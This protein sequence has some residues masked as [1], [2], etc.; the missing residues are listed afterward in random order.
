MLL[1]PREA[2]G[3]QIQ[4]GPHAA[5]VPVEDGYSFVSGR[6][7]SVGFRRVPWGS[8]RVHGLKV[9]GRTSIQYLCA[10]ASELS[11][12]CEGE[13]TE[14]HPSGSRMKAMCFI[15]PSVRRFW[16]RTPSCSKR[17]QAASTSSTVMAMWPK[18][19]PG[20]ALPEA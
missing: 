5:G 15:L 2:I 6:F 13:E 10:L 9:L 16:K 4:E 3:I 12:Q 7:D 14:T 18:P 11:S 20:S 8:A 1:V 17:A 19:R